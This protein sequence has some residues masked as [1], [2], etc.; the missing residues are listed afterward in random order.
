MSVQDPVCN[1]MHYAC[2]WDRGASRDRGDAKA[3]REA[4]QDRSA[5]IRK[6]ERGLLPKPA[7]EPSEEP[8]E[9]EPSNQF[10]IPGLTGEP[11]VSSEPL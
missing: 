6:R 5:V 8:E 9:P 10:F 1:D 11:G 2:I 3:Q 4:A 7:P